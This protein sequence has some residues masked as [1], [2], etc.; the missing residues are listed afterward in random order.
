VEVDAPHD[1]ARGADARQVRSAGAI[2]DLFRPT[3]RVPVR[4]RARDSRTSRNH[5]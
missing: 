1:E 5:E 3:I 4:P 2:Q